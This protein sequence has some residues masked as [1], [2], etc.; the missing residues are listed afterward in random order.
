ML[1]KG[2]FV[3]SW[4][5]R[6]FILT[7]SAL[8]YFTDESKTELKGYVPIVHTSRVMHRDG[9]S[10]QFKFGL[11][12]GKRLLEIACESDELRTSW[13]TTIQELINRLQ[14]QGSRAGAGGGTAPQGDKGTIFDDLIVKN[15]YVTVT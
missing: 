13:K 6:Y 8:Q 3:R 11:L 2:S 14:L 1:K 9:S 4:K 10:H 7:P 15:R 12:T 5:R